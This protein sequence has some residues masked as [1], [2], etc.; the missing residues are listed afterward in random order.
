MPAK[1]LNCGAFER[2]MSLDVLLVSIGMLACAGVLLWRF[3][4]ETDGDALLTTVAIV[5]V[6]VLCLYRVRLGLLGYMQG[7]F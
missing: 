1:Q 2:S 3:S 4:V 7:L 5:L 6:I